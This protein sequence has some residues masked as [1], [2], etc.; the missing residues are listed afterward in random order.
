MADGSEVQFDYHEGWVLWRGVL[1]PVA[2]IA[3]EEQSLAGMALLWGSLLS[4]EALPGA[5]VSVS[6]L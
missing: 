3:A 5:E 1:R 2:V 6:E 4:V